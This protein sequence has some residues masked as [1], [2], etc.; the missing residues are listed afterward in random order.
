MTSPDRFDV[1]TRPLIQHF[2]QAKNDETIKAPHYCPFVMGTFLSLV[3]SPQ[4]V[5]CG[6]SL[7]PCHDT[8]IICKLTFGPL[9]QKVST[10]NTAE[11]N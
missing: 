8:V 2:V 6:Q 5:S 3:D 7:N 9:E 10:D 4:R 11:P 1:T